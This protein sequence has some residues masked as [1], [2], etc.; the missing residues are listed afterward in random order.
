MRTYQYLAFDIHCL[1]LCL[2]RQHVA[3]RIANYTL[4]DLTDKA[5]LLL[6]L[7]WDSSHKSQS[8]Y[9]TNQYIFSLSFALMDILLFHRYPAT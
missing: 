9:H 5:F 3:L 2:A 4:P 6:R 8:L 7:V 1:H